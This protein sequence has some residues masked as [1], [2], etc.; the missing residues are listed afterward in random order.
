MFFTPIFYH[1]HIQQSIKHIVFPISLNIKSERQGF[2]VA[3]MC[4]FKIT[5]W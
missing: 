1:K 4:V 3:S 2:Y 5:S